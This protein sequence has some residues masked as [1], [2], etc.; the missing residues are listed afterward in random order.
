MSAEVGRSLADV[1]AYRARHD[2]ASP[3]LVFQPLDG[4]PERWPYGDFHLSVHRLASG[5]MASG[6]RPGDRCVIHLPNSPAFLLAFWALQHLGVTAFPTI[7]GYAGAELKYVV[8][9]SE[10]WGVI[11]DVPRSGKAMSASEGRPVVISDS[12]AEPLGFGRML[13][14]EPLPATPA[15]APACGAGLGPRPGSAWAPPRFCAPP[16]WGSAM[17]PRAASARTPRRRN[18]IHGRFQRDP[19]AGRPEAYGQRSPSPRGGGGNGGAGR[20]PSSRNT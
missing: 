9:H 13:Q 6:L 4:T 10:S 19:T 1:L 20:T 5:L 15:P 11:T 8:E 2:G 12:S 14:A 16:R 3:F 18:R 7:D 17:L